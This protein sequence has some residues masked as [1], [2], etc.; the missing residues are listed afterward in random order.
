VAF[1][2]P[3]DVRLMAT[4]ELEGRSTVVVAIPRYEVS[5]ALTPVIRRLYPHIVRFIAVDGDEDRQRFEAIGMRTVI[6]RSIPRG[7]EL[8]AA[9]LAH[10]GVDRRKIAAWMGREQDRAL[11][12]VAS[13][14]VV[15]PSR[16][17]PESREQ[18]A[19]AP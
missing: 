1:G 13:E 8:A 3:R 7:L 11:E 16:P 9:V 18:G 6:S 15:A 10:H 14:S 19:G 5:A 4:L 12:A 2:D 17:V